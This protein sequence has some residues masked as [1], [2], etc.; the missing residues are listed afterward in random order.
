MG[1]VGQVCLAYCRELLFC[2]FP[3]AFKLIRGQFFEGAWR[4][5]LHLAEPLTETQIA[6]AQCHLSIDAEVAAEIHD[7]EQQIA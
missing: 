2:R 3:Q 7:G 4:G 1:F 5:Q 6:A